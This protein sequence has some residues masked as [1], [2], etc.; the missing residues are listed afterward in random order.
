MLY[1][2][3]MNK[4]V[5][6]LDPS[7]WRSHLKRVRPRVRALDALAIQLLFPLSKAIINGKA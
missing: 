2:L 6:W 3:L 5:G 1:T 4:L 7:G